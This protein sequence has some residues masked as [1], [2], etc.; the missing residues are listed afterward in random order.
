MVQF[1]LFAVDGQVP[2]TSWGCRAHH[3]YGELMGLLFRA[4][5][6]GTRLGRGRDGGDAGSLL[7]G[8]LP[9]N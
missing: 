1:L 4:V 9:P 5:Y 3:G 2:F 6:I 7:P 8:V